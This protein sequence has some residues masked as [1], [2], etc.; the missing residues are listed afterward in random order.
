M[1]ILEYL[2]SEGSSMGPKDS[3][4]ED[5]ISKLNEQNK[6]IKCKDKLRCMF[7]NKKEAL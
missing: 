5:H 4:C 1:E 6:V 7:P 3:K 2:I